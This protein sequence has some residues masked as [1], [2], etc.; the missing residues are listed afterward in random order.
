MHTGAPEPDSRAQLLLAIGHATLGKLASR[1]EIH[2]LPVIDD[3]HGRQSIADLSG[4]RC[5][6]IGPRSG[7]SPAADEF[8]LLPNLDRCSG[9]SHG[10]IRY[11]IIKP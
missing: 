7:Y 11:G 1:R 2:S 10:N 6:W 9:N 3:D 4:S 8:Q 5:S